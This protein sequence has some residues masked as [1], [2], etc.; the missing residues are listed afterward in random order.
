M[1]IGLSPQG[2][3][4]KT[5]QHDGQR[6]AAA[7]MTQPVVTV[8]LD[9]S[10]QA[11][12]KLLSDRRISAV[13]V[14]D[15]DRL[16]GIVSEADLL[17]R[18]EIGTDR[19]ASRARWWML[20]FSRGS[21]AD[22][23]IR[24]HAMRVSDIMTS[25]VVTVDESASLSEVVGLL[26]RHRIKRLPVLS[27]GRVAGIISRSDLVRAIALARPA[28]PPRPSP[29]TDRDIERGLAREL[30]RQ[31]WWRST[32]ASISVAKGVVHFHGLVFTQSERDASRVAAEA[33]PGVRE[34]RDHR[35]RHEQVPSLE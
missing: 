25:E 3:Q 27:A 6:N 12:A 35:F 19:T 33:L 13:P 34:V 2:A 30:N 11:A 22:D 26:E 17:R 4:M 29:R 32:Y 7:I 5:S 10:V 1:N 24:T 9:T 14:V 18:H 15:K 23:Y 8:S 21:S 31:S 20:P 16:V 28:A